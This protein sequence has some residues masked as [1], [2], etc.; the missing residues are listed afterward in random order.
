[1]TM[2]LLFKPVRD[3]KAMFVGLKKVLDVDWQ[4]NTGSDSGVRACFPN[5]DVIGNTTTVDE[6][7]ARGFDFYVAMKGR[8][9]Q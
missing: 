4:R 5:V 7:V 1:M 6:D 9:F 8:A 3:L 2:Q